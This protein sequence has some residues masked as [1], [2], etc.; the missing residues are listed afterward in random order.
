MNF[1]YLTIGAYLFGSVPF[2]LLFA[3]L[4]GVDL[5]K[6]GSG[7]IGATNVIRALGKKWGITCFILDVAKGLLP[8]ILVPLLGLIDAEPT[9]DQLLSWLAVGVAAILGHVFSLYL[10]FKGGKG[11]ATSLGV[12]LGLWPYFT[13]CGLIVFA[14]WFVSVKIWRYVS[15]AS[16]L[17]AGA[18]P[19]ILAVAIGIQKSWTFGN[20][21]P[22][23]LV[24]VP[25]PLLVIVRHWTN[26]Q[27]IR[28]G[29]ED[30]IGSRTKEN[31]RL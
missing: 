26:I 3:R 2:G 15:L 14:V 29:T 12:V 21:W 28:N 30:K 6:I 1:A 5:R 23:F 11:V 24:A 10:G 18:F 27:R 9:A 25:I 13:L 8:M 31:S 22:L 17:A 19:I 16:V 7:N 20:L 4:Q